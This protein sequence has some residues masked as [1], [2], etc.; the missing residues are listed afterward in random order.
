MREQQLLHALAAIFA[1]L[2]QPKT[3]PAD[4]AY[5]KSIAYDAINNITCGYCHER[6]TPNGGWHCPHCGGC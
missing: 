5:A 1:A 2:N 4:V 3:F 6:Y